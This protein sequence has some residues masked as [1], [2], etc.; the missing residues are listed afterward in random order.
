MYARML[1]YTTALPENRRD[2]IPMDYLQY[3]DWSEN[4]RLARIDYLDGKLTAEEFLRKIDTMHDLE[5]LH[6]GRDADLT[7]GDG[8]AEDG[9]RQHW[10]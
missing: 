9:G 6:C 7:G 5:G 2:L 1:R 4:A 8:L 3:G 10:L